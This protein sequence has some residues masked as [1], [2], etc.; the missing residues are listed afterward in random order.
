MAGHPPQ[1]RLP[2]SYV[3]SLPTRREISCVPRPSFFGGFLVGL[4]SPPKVK[5]TSHGHTGRT[6]E[7]EEQEKEEIRDGETQ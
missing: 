5:S 2:M 4:S 7:D 6:D 3:S 1:S